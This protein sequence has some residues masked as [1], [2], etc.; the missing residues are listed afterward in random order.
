MY[1]TSSSALFLSSAS[2][3]CVSPSWP[4]AAITRM[5][6]SENG[7]E[8]RVAGATSMLFEYVTGEYWLSASPTSGG[9]QG[10]YD[11]TVS[12]SNFD[13]NSSE[14]S[15]IFSGTDANGMERT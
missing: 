2:L 12:G 9:A 7:K 5:D 3:T 14:Y 10:G 1:E 8:V 11:I 13:T 6:L 4:H 15:M